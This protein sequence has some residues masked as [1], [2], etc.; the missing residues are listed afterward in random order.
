MALVS[1]GPFLVKEIWGSLAPSKVSF[2]ERHFG[3]KKMILDPPRRIGSAIADWCCLCN[4]DEESA[5]HILLHCGAICSLW[6]LLFLLFN[7]SWALPYMMKG[8]LLG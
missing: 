5:N 6:Y 8:V 7:V 3:E 4:S 1:R 2:F